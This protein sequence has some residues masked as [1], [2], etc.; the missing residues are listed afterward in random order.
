VES[1]TIATFVVAA[2]TALLVIVTFG[3]VLANV[4]LVAATFWQVRI[5]GRGFSLSIRPL[6]A[7]PS[8]AE[9][10][11]PDEMILFGAPGRDSVKVKVGA[12]WFRPDGRQVS[13]PFRNIGQGV[14]VITAATTEPP[15]TGSIYVTRKF[16]PPG[17]SVRVNISRASPPEIGLGQWW[18]MN[19]FAILV[20]YTDAAGGQPQ[21]SRADF[22]QAA[23]Q[24]PWIEKISV[25]ERGKSE[26]YVVGRS[27]V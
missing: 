24:S 19:P 20:H 22:R 5:T 14:A 1:A 3:L 12:L 7:D 17:E 2:V 23:T 21:V 25:F 13:L 4:A 9:G 8:P 15:T 26:P 11:L 18:A 27:S 16:V 6:L 10:E